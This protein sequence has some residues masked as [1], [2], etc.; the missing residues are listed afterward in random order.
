MGGAQ[1][2]L[3][4]RLCHRQLR[5]RLGIQFSLMTATYWVQPPRAGNVAPQAHSA[6][7]GKMYRLRWNTVI[8]AMR[9][10]HSTVLVPLSN[11]F[12]EVV[13]AVR[14]DAAI[15]FLGLN[16]AEGEEMTVNARRGGDRTDE[17][18]AASNG[19]QRFW[20]RKAGDCRSTSSAVPDNNCGGEGCGR[21]GRLVRREDIG[22]ATQRYRSGHNPGRYP[23]FYASVEQPPFE[24][25]SMRN[26]RNGL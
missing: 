15:A 4:R 16:R 17:L 8:P 12:M 21:D 1:G 11:C 2:A 14:A 13:N 23:D 22:T 25:Y 9:A 5:R 10:Q 19:C 7:E 3:Q 24:D 18:P 6:E 20:Q 26:A